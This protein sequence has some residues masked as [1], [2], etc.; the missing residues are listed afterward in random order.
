LSVAQCTELFSALSINGMQYPVQATHGYAPAIVSGGMPLNLQ[1]HTIADTPVLASGVSLRYT[2]D[3]NPVGPVLTDNFAW[4]L[5]TSTLPDGT[6]SISVL[7]VNEPAPGTSCYTF[8]G[9]QYSFVISNSGSPIIS[10]QLLPV[11]SPPAA[12]GPPVPQ[13]ADF[14]QYPGLQPHAAPHPFPYQ[15]IPPAGGATVTDLWGEQLLHATSNAGEAKPAYWKLKN[16]SIV[17]EPL[18]SSLF[19]CDDLRRP[20]WTFDVDGSAWEQRK[21]RFD[22]P[23]D[24]VG[25]ASYSVFAPNLDGPG[26]YGIGMDGR[27]FL[28]QMDGSIQTLAGWVTSRGAT[29][30]HY[31][32]NS[33]PMSAVHKQQTLVGTFDI[34]FNFPTDLAIDPGNHSHILIADMNNHRIA[35]VDLSQSPPAISTYAGVPGTAGYRDGPAATS[36]FN[37]PSS[38]AVAPDRT[39][40]VADAENSV[41]RKIDPLGNVS[42]LAGLGSAYEPTTVVAAG[43]PLLYAP[44]TAVSFTSAYINYPNVIRFDSKGNIVLGETVTQTIRYLDLSAKTVTTIAQL[45]STGNSF[46]EQ[47]WLDVDRA[48]NIGSRDDIIASLVAAHQN[49]LYRIPITGSASV[50]PPNITTHSTNPIYGG[51][52]VRSAMPWTAAPWSIAIDDQE[53]RAMVSGVHSSGVVSLRLLQPTDPTFQLNLSDYTAGR[54]IWFSGTVPNFPFGSRPSFAAVHGYEGHSGLG[55]VQNFDD[56]VSMSDAQLAT[57][58]QNGGEGA[59]PRPELTGNDLRNLIYYV[60]RT[61]LGGDRITPGPNSAVTTPPAVSAITATEKDATDVSVSWATSTP[62]LG[63]IAWGT[64][65]GTYFGWS[66]IESGYSTTHSLNVS[67][68][69]AGQVIYFVV[70]AKDQSGNQNVSSEQSIALH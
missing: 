53:G 38:I 4:T 9:R 2:V 58:L 33:I 60:R 22:G 7:Y 47:L 51:H 34:E 5:D 61:A 42:T 26:F 46:G 8:S 54:N 59:V 19:L 16:G 43:S 29:P 23:Q 48:G 31:L 49:G 41:I 17:E 27:L 35:L 36:L 52:T 50:P 70:R 37:Q 32:D 3:N 24:D 25:L 11:I 45:S 14:I 68:L 12:N 44:Q 66:P 62:T 28:M 64:S 67:N 57:Y 55:N 13:Y 40:Y 20:G 56:M 39:I 15:F 69:P 65:S 21:G 63:F 10:P 1:F 18:F 30:Y 6:H